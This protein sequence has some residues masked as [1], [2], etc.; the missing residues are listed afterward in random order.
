MTDYLMYVENRGEIT[1][2]DG[3]VFVRF[4]LYINSILLDSDGWENWDGSNKVYSI[5]T[6]VNNDLIVRSVWENAGEST[7]IEDELNI[8]AI[9]TGI[10]LR[11][12]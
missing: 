11:Q 10:N 3:D 7:I 4:N 1:R 12:L 9:P 8:I 5:D 6:L 2:T